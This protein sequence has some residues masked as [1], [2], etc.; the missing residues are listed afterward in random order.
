[1]R[2]LNNVFWGGNV[3]EINEQQDFLKTWPLDRLK[4]IT[5]DEYTNLDRE[6]SF[7]YW[8]EN[9]TE[10]SGSIY[11]GSAFKFGI[12][13]RLNTK[14]ENS[15]PMYSTDGTYSWYTKYGKSK[16]EAFGNIRLLIINA[17]QSSVDGNLANL[18]TIDLGDA[19][20]WKIAYLY[21]PS[22]VIPLFKKS[23]LIRAC[24]KKGLEHSQKKNIS[25]LQKFL[26]DLKLPDIDSHEYSKLLWE[27]FNLENF[28]SVI[29]KFIEQ[30]QT[31]SLKRVGYPTSY[32]GYS[33]KL[34][35]GVGNV[36]QIPWIGFI[37]EPNTITNGIYPVYLYYKSVNQLVL[38]YGKSETTE[39]LSKWN[40]E[41]SL[42]TINEWFRGKYNTSPPRYGES[43][44][45]SVYDL[46]DELDPIV[47]QNDLDEII[48]EYEKQN[49]VSDNPASR[50]DIKNPEISNRIWIIAPGEGAFKWDEFLKDG[51]IALGWDLMPDL[52]NFSD[53][54]KVREKLLT[55]YPEES[56]SHK[57]NSLALWEFLSVMQIGD[58]IIA[59]RGLREYVGYGI[60]TSE[61]YYDSAKSEYRHRRYVEWKKSGSWREEVHNIVLKTLTDITQYTEYV[62]RLKRLI[63][64]GQDSVIPTN[65]NHWWLN[66]NPKFW[67]I[68]DFEVGQEQTYTTHNEKGNKRARF[69]YFQA[70]KPGDLV[71]GYESSPIKKVVA[72][73]EITKGA[74]IDEDNG[75]EQISFVI[76]K[77]LPEPIS[78][79]QLKNFT[80]LA[81]SE[82]MRNNQGSLFKLTSKEYEAIIGNEIVSSH[83]EY[84][85]DN[86]LKDLFI[87]KDEIDEILESL[88][89][90]Q[91]IILQ[92]PPGTGKTFMA[93]RLAFLAMG[94]RDEARIEMVQFHQSY[95][96]EDFIQGFR[97]QE[98]GSFKLENGVFYRFCKKAMSDPNRKYFFI[99]DEINRGNL[100]KVFGELML[101]IEKDKRSKDYAVSLTYS[102][103][104]ETRFFIPDNVYLIGTM[105]TA[106]RS[107]AVVDYALRRR[108][109]FIDVLPVF[110]IKFRNNLINNGA[111]EAIADRVIN[112]ITELNQLITKDNNLGNGFQI[113]HSYFCPN[114]QIKG[115]DEWYRF[116]VR[117][118]IGPLLNE[119]WFDN[120][121]KAK[122]IQ[123]SLLN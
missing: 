101:L 16:E 27:E 51:V 3:S 23:V 34:S 105:N 94:E 67:K 1:M 99:I 10:S 30:S 83:P 117:H 116:L 89:Y 80:Q 118:E 102:L 50:Q 74:H 37:K 69:E 39:C 79:A 59:K 14:T 90:K 33:V 63:G 26:L 60:V 76:Q 22:I 12:F 35:F 84:S 108:F 11:G 77:F 54:E 61:Y 25:G 40:N 113:G 92:G 6:S 100:S 19:V 48:S 2:V 31:D 91:N 41:D 71:I 24:E 107:L 111:D 120:L 87:E 114:S 7:I 70:A 95:S 121:D 8:L 45:K 112:K 122:S 38:A 98:D 104:S 52:S 42:K 78:W 58:I 47:I 44:I 115:D 106:D 36:A 15:N 96:Y 20:K 53:R 82:I 4:N 56:K 75:D 81:D 109:A 32:K 46:N 28:Y 29:V 5:L 17:A 123:E 97:P 21:N 18:D 57:N 13:R 110:N 73:L 49:F 62:D 43:L 68:T 85:I 65:L 86:A 103:S 9:K 66:A 119:Y 55:V 88:E 64:I 72:V 93:K